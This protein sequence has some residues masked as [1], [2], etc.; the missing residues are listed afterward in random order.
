IRLYIRYDNV[1]FKLQSFS[2]PTEQTLNN[3]TRI[4]GV[5][6]R[7]VSHEDLLRMQSARG[8]DAYVTAPGTDL[9]NFLLSR[10]RIAPLPRRNCTSKRWVPPQKKDRQPLMKPALLVPV[11]LLSKRFSVGLSGR[12]N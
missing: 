11:L 10:M 2:L 4:L 3:K 5:M 12:G 8:S 1:R 9:R 7:V 6:W